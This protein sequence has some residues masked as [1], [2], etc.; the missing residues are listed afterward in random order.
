MELWFNDHIFKFI[1]EGTNRFPSQQMK[2]LARLHKNHET[3]PLFTLKKTE[4][5]NFPNRFQVKLPI[6]SLEDIDLLRWIVGFGGQVKV[7][8]PPEL[9]NKV[10]QIGGAISLLY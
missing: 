3:N 9:V 4:D 1:S 8:N 6:W 5:K 2:M 7:I 10:K